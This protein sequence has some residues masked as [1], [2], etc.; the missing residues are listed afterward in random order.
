[1]AMLLDSVA[2]FDEKVLSLGFER[3]QLEGLQ[4]QGI[5]TLGDAAFVVQ[6]EASD[7]SEQMNKL[8]GKVFGADPLPG[9]LAKLRRLL[10]MSNTLAAVEFRRASEEDG[11][12][13]PK[14]EREMRLEAL[15]KKL[16]CV[17]TSGY[18]EP[19][20]SLISLVFMAKERNILSHIS[21]AQCTSRR[22]ELMGA[23]SEDKLKMVDGQLKL[24]SAPALECD[25]TTPLTARQAMRRRSLAMELVGVASYEILET[26][27]E[28][29]FGHLQEPPPSS[30]VPPTLE[31]IL[32]ADME[33]WSMVGEHLSKGLVADAT[34]V[35]PIDKAIQEY[36]VHARVTHNL[37][38]LPALS[39]KRAL[40]IKDNN[41]TKKAKTS[42]MS[43]RPMGK[44]KAKA[45][46][47]KA[48][49]ELVGLAY[50]NGACY[51]YNLRSCD[52][53]D[54]PHKHICAKCGGKHPFKDCRSSSH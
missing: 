23:K 45:R 26:I 31:R 41:D 53:G 2:V 3:A 11:C 15:R 9:D 47:P 48:P 29:M 39:Q 40:E 24:V 37:Q 54:C 18:N 21:L 30:Y 42:S 4:K 20:L 12:K 7:A 5:K 1:M 33:L 51:S 19:S 14:A 43:S 34:G 44:A 52:R 50:T 17:I 49:K 13:M 27:N 22:Q 25:V 32:R 36:C 28:E 35:L 10:T 8:A 46:A 38:P 6:L 16:G